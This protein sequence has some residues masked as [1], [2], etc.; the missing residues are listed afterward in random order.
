MTKTI[1]EEIAELRA[2][3]MPDLVARY[4]EV[5]G[6]PPRVKHREFLW[7]RIAWKIQEQRFGGLSEVAKRRLDELIAEIRLPLDE[8]TRTVAGRLAPAPK[9]GAPAVG[10]TIVREWRGQTIEV[11]VV[12]N[13]FEWNGAPYRSLSAVARAVTGAHWNGNLFFKVGRRRR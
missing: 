11:R 10:G 2:M 9:R 1:P 6:R 8:A 5:F 13:G 4:E 7:K 12:E 3:P